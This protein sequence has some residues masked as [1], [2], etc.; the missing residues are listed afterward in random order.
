MVAEGG[1]TTVERVFERIRSQS[2]GSAVDLGC[3]NGRHLEKLSKLADKVFAIEPDSRRISNA[4]SLAEAKELTNVVFFNDDFSSIGKLGCT[5]NL[6][7]CSHVIQHIG[8]NDAKNLV[9]ICANVL[10]ADGALLL[11]TTRSIRH[12]DHYRKVWCNGHCI[13]FESITSKEYEDRCNQNCPGCLPVRLFSWNSLSIL[14][15]DRFNSLQMLP[16]NNFLFRKLRGF[17][18]VRETA[19]RLPLLKRWIGSDVLVI[20]KRPIKQ[21]RDN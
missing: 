7:F 11:V 21:S 4:K 6:I 8:Q 19:S 2:I 3:G 16:Y 9:A 17:F 1:I 13:E 12:Q 5:P 20:C 15:R 14:L 10:A 18:W